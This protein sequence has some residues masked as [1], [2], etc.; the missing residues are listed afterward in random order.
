MNQSALHRQTNFGPQDIAVLQAA[1]QKTIEGLNIVPALNDEEQR[2]VATLVIAQF[3][4]GDMDFRRIAA[5]VIARLSDATG[6]MAARSTAACKTRCIVLVSTA[7]RAWGGT[8]QPWAYQTR[9]SD[10]APRFV[11]DRL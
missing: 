6:R 11:R 4:I 3:Q 8:G 2:W 5:R 10:L 1:Y 7:G 9:R